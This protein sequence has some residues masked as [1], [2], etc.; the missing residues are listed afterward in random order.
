V[1]AAV[2]QHPRSRVLNGHFFAAKLATDR[3]ADR[4]DLFGAADHLAA[5]QP[6]GHTHVNTKFV[7]GG[8]RQDPQ[9]NT[10]TILIEDACL[11]LLPEGEE[12]S[13]HHRTTNQP[14][15]FRAYASRQ[16]KT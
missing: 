5:G 13:V 9:R 6:V 16:P 2:D 7:L 10:V 3:H 11:R 14:T 12:L 1:G 15:R 8:R 4:L